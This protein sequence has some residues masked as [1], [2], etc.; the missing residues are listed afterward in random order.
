[1]SSCGVYFVKY[2]VI[3]IVKID[4]DFAE[5]SMVIDAALSSH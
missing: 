4:L 2:V 5:Y 3:Y 1:M